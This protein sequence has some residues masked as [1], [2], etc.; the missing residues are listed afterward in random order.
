MTTFKPTHILVTTV[1]SFTTRTPV[2]VVDEDWSACEPG[3]GAQ[4]VTAE[5]W[6]S[7]GSASYT[8]DADECLCCNGSPTGWGNGSWELIEIADAN[9]TITLH[10]TVSVSVENGTPRKVY[11]TG[12]A[13]TESNVEGVNDVSDDVAS[14]ALREIAKRLDFRGEF[15]AWV[16]NGDHVVGTLAAR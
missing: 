7:E 6:E 9:M 13:L 5:E 2:A 1:G 4:L 10:R 3:P 12:D 16:D 15:V 11:F 14:E 8:L